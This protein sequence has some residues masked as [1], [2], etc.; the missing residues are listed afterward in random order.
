MKHSNAQFYFVKTKQK[1]SQLASGLGNVYFPGNAGLGSWN[2][3]TMTL[4]LELTQTRFDF[5]IYKILKFLKSQ[6]PGIK[7]LESKVLRMKIQEIIL[8]R[9]YI[10]EF[11]PT[12]TSANFLSVNFLVFNRGIES[13]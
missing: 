8:P 11:Y 10:Q 6:L 9:I 5:W 1:R 3:K 7:T 12:E 2:L 4:F 13:L